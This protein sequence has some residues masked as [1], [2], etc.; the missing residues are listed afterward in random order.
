MIEL[1]VM[2][3]RRAAAMIGEE[4]T[5][6][7]GP[8]EMHKIK[9]SKYGAWGWEAQP[10]RR[11]EAGGRVGKIHRFAWRIDAAEVKGRPGILSERSGRSLA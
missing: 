9:I 4:F 6:A 10:R 11:P 2:A 8:V 7:K 5:N 3:S 1:L